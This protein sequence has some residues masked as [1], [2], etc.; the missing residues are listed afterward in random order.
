[1]AG[2]I[3]LGAGVGGVALGHLA[4]REEF[5]DCAAARPWGSSL[6]C[7]YQDMTSEEYWRL[8]HLVS[9]D[10]EAAIGCSSTYRTIHRIASENRQFLQRCNE[11]ADFWRS[12]TYSL[13]AG[14][15]IALG[16]I[17]DRAN[18]SFSVEDL[19][20]QTIE[21]PGFFSKAEIRKRKREVLKLFG[22][23][24]DPDWMEPYLANLSEPT[25]ADLELLRTELQ[26]HAAKFPDVYGKIRHKYY[27]HRSTLTQQAVDDL[28]GQTDV[29][30]VASILASIYDMIRGI[31]DMAANGTLPG[32]WHPGHYDRLYRVY[33]TSAEDFIRRMLA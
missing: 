30:E 1:M 24:P 27:A 8:F 5:R 23:D 12:I 28:F 14:L 3:S 7:N 26:P 25:R 33:Q 20:K 21:H 13:E 18:G 6:T 31:Q 19:V 29:N 11:H 17:F 15:F 32:Q 4:F 16:R 22:D 9:G 2:I 10:V